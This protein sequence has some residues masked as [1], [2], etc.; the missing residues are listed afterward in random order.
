MVF[1]GFQGARNLSAQAYC[2]LVVGMR[3]IS[4]IF[5]PLAT[6]DTACHVPRC[7]NLLHRKLSAEKNTNQRELYRDDWSGTYV[8]HI[9]VV[10][11]SREW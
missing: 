11:L 3:V 5:L 2:A 8:V 4:T 1:V 7:R 9:G 10:L 6:Y